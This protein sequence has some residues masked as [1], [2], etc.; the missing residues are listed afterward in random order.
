MRVTVDDDGTVTIA[1]AAKGVDES[2]QASAQGTM[3]KADDERK[4]ALYVGYAAMRADTALAKDQHRDFATAQVIEDNAHNWLA[5]G[6]KL[7]LLHQQSTQ[8]FET[9]ESGIH[10]GPD[11]V[12][13][14][15]DGTQQVIREGDWLVAVRAKTPQ[16]WSLIKSGALGGVSVQGRAKRRVP[17][18]EA[19][20][21]LR[22]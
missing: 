14:A 19:L 10:R 2:A 20:A 5:K 21:S 6:A 18:A 9:V 1:P 22:S 4:V 11:W 13:K 3:L 7:G 17:S 12:M 16:A 15:A 8:D